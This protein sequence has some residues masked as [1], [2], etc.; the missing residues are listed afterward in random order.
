ML[1]TP[2]FLDLSLDLFSSFWGNYGHEGIWGY[3]QS[4]TYENELSGF[5]QKYLLSVRTCLQVYLLSMLLEQNSDRRINDLSA[6]V[7]QIMMWGNF[8]GDM[9]LLDKTVYQYAWNSIIPKE[10]QFQSTKDAE[11]HIYNIANYYD[12][13]SLLKEINALDGARAHIDSEST[14][15]IHNVPALKVSAPFTIED[16]DLCLKQF[17]T[18]LYWPRPKQLAWGR[19]TN[20]NPIFK[21]SDL[22]SVTIFYRGDYKSLLFAVRRASGKYYPDYFIEDISLEMISEIGSVNDLDSI[23]PNN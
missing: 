4:R 1:S 13:V 10:F 8:P 17:K 21:D 5:D 11:S 15:G 22:D 20:A 2:L 18:F 9:N 16:L 14:A 12:E 23:K 7:R 6:W 19:F 3:L